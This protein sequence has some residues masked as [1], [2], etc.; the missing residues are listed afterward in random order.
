MEIG[1]QTNQVSDFA[2]YGMEYPKKNYKHLIKQKIG[3]LYILD[4]NAFNMS[5]VCDFCN[6]K[7][8]RYFQDASGRPNHP[9]LACNNC[10][11]FCNR[12]VMAAKNMFYIVQEIWGGNGE[13]KDAYS[14]I[15]RVFQF[16]YF[17]YTIKTGTLPS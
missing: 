14:A 2:V 7:Y 11:F 1:L 5:K 3:E 16:V 9:I 4:I 10:I 6:S 12:D 17:A 13:L 8:F 15:H